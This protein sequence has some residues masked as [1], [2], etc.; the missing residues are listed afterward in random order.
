MSDNKKGM[1]ERVAQ[2][3]IAFGNPKGDPE[4]IDW[5]R[6]EKQCSNILDEY[7]ELQVA[8]AV[9][10]LTE[11]RDALCDINVFALG[12]FHFA[13]VEI[14]VD[15]AALIVPRGNPA[16]VDW[17]AFAV[18]ASTF[19]TLY[20]LVM[21]GIKA[22]SLPQAAYYISL[23]V[24]NVVRAYAFLGL[25][26][27]ADMEAVVAGVMTRFCQDED[28]YAMTAAKY[29]DLGVEFYPE[30]TFPTVCLKSAK[31]QQDINGKNYP[32]GKFLKSIS[33]S[34]TVFPAVPA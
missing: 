10:D 4:N 20:D 8:I 2:M 33:F 14:E 15:S 7:K 1:Y 5:E 13:G 6:L 26:V 16:N 17:D 12:G 18:G 11:V 19:V 24:E 30:G 3:N 22:R 29:L 25:D 9:R 21:E 31:D 28:D 34:E 32:K 27:E 23:V